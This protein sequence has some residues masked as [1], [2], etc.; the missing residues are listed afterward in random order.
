MLEQ[1]PIILDRLT[2]CSRL[3]TRR[4]SRGGLADRKRAATKLSG[5]EKPASGGPDL[6][7]SFVAKLVRCPASHRASRLGYGQ[8]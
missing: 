5:R 1:V 6:P 8:I 4:G 3:L 7:I 2:G